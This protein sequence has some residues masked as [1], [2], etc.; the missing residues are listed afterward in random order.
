MTKWM[1]LGVVAGVSL[2]AFSLPAEARPTA[3]SHTTHVAHV[4][5][6]VSH[7]SHKAPAAHATPRTTVAHTRTTDPVWTPHPTLP[8]P[9]TGENGKPS[10]LPQHH[11]RPP[12]S[13]LPPPPHR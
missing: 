12:P 7:A 13:M 5:H 4:T 8:P 1:F 9:G 11:L 6:V 3:T 10:P 2:A